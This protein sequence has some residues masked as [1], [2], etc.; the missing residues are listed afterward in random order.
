MYPRWTL[1][2]LLPHVAGV[3]HSAC[4][5]RGGYLAVTLGA[6]VATTRYG[7]VAVAAGGTYWYS[8]ANSYYLGYRYG[9]YDYDYDYDNDYGDDG[10][11][12]A[13]IRYGDTDASPYGTVLVNGEQSQITRTIKPTPGLRVARVGVN[14]SDL[15][16]TVTKTNAT[17]VYNDG[18]KLSG[19]IQTSLCSATAAGL[20]SRATPRWASCPAPAPSRPA[21]PRSAPGSPSSSPCGRWRP[22]STSTSTDP[23]AYLWPPRARGGQSRSCGIATGCPIRGIRQ[24]P[25]FVRSMSH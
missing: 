11:D 6:D 25:T 20:C 16:G 18:V 14:S 9:D 22:T 1:G 24:P 2:L 5:R 15:A 17:V 21:T 19:M 4:E 23:T 7:L 8:T 12:Y 10:N 3:P 13:V